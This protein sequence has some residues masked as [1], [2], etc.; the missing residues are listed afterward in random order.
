M[1]KNPNSRTHKA[2]Y[3]L[4]TRRKWI[5]SGTPIQNNLTELWALLKWLEVE[6]YASHR[7]LFKRQIESAIKHGHPN[8]IQRLQT[9]MQ[10]I[11]MRRTKSDQVNGKPIV[12]LPNKSVTITELKFTEEETIIYKAWESEG[13]EIIQKYQQKGTL[14]N[15]YAH[16][17]AVM[18]RLRQLCCHR[19]LL[20][21][22]W[23][24]V[25][26]RELEDQV[27]RDMQ[28]NN[29]ANA[30]INAG[31]EAESNDRSKQLAEQL[32]DMIKEG[33][34]DECSICLGEFTQPVITPCAHIY[35]K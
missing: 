29:S 14:L 3:E 11:C 13:Q 17:F 34:S 21:V 20:P 33:L 1:I 2:C 22:Q 30:N 25:D 6:P 12:D 8:G 26:M 24:E 23:N 35:C 5:I 27:R 15:N 32:R 10:A 4:N 9:L 31:A 19:E 28:A 18:M 16:V 7:T